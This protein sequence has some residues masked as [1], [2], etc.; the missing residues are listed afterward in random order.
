MSAAAAVTASLKDLGVHLRPEYV[1]AALQQRH[2]GTPEEQLQ[3]V[4]AQFLSADMNA[5]GAGCLPP[6]LPTQHNT[7]LH[8]RFV[9]QIDEAADTAAPA[10]QRWAPALPM[11]ACRKT[12]IRKSPGAALTECHA[13][14]QVCKCG[15]GEAVSEAL[16]ERWCAAI[17]PA[18]HGRIGHT[19]CVSYDVHRRPATCSS[20][21]V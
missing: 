12:V 18:C 3:W 21:R 9:L 10:K 16:L 17:S 7:V 13:C 20:I 19:S 11:H 4:Y 2:G 6:D 5:C 8:G 15:L 14:Q 1:T